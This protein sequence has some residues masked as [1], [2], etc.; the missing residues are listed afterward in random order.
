LGY[1]GGG[2]NSSAPADDPLRIFGPETVRD[3]ELGAKTKWEWAGVRGYAN[4]SLFQALYDHIQ[5]TNSIPGS[6]VV[7]TTNLAAGKIRGIELEGEV[8]PSSW[9]RLAGN[10]TY[11]DAKYTDWTQTT[12]CAALPA[13]PLCL[14]Q[15]PT[16]TVIVDHAN[17][18]ATFDGAT[19]HFQPDIFSDSPRLT[20]SIQPAILLN[21]LLGA[22]V[23]VSANIYHRSSAVTGAASNN[24]SQLIG[25]TPLTENTILGLSSQ[26]FVNPGFTRVDMRIDWS[27]VVDSGVNLYLQVTNL[28]NLVYDGSSQTAFGVFGVASATIEPPRMWYLGVRYDL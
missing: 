13:F 8:V 6:A 10:I 21:R 22:D 14:G 20:Y 19:V 9:F 26:P 25:V 17:G 2:V 11:L 23:T 27:H 5:R 7:E 15:S 16:A 3:V 12:S 28:T 18:A 4:F 1:K 24:T